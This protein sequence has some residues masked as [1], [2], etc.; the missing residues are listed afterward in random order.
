MNSNRCCN[1]RD[2]QPTCYANCSNCPL[3]ICP[4]SNNN[5]SYQQQNSNLHYNQCQYQQPLKHAF[6]SIKTSDNINYGDNKS[7]P[8]PNHINNYNNTFIENVKINVATPTYNNNNYESV[9]YCAP[10]ININQTTFS[11]RNWNENNG[12]IPNA[13]ILPTFNNNING[14]NININNIN[15]ENNARNTT[16]Y[17]ST[18][19][20]SISVPDTP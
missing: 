18:S 10:N 11:V 15:L 4:L 16:Q 1:C 19:E 9:R 3:S 13:K 14:V 7:I 17:S 20:R 6:P 12:Y 2:C 5:I 8:Y